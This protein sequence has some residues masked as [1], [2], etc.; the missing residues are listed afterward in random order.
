MNWTPNQ[1][2]LKG[3][4]PKTGEKIV[5]TSIQ[6]FELEKDLQKACEDYLR[7]RDHIPFHMRDNKGV[8]GNEMGWPDIICCINGQYIAFELKV[9]KRQLSIEQ[10]SKR[11]QIEKAGGRFYVVRSFRTF[12]SIVKALEETKVIYPEVM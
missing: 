12:C 8:K 7:I 4:N 6:E 1:L 11:R 5:D 2:K 10:T 3:F 9:K